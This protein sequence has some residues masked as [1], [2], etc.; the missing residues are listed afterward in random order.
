MPQPL[1]RSESR[2]RFVYLLQLRYA[3]RVFRWTS[4]EAVDIA[5]DSGTLH[6]RAGLPVSW[7]D[8]GD[9]LSID[10]EQ[11][12]VSFDALNMPEDVD[13]A[14][15]VEAGHDLAAA[16]GELS[17][18]VTGRTYEERIP[19]LEGRAVAP[20]YGG[21]GEPI[22]LTIE[23]RL[24]DDASTL[25]N[26][27]G[28]VTPTTW[29]L[30][31][32]AMFG[33]AYP[34]VVGRPGRYVEADGTDGKTT[35]SPALLV[36]TSSKRFLVAGH[37]VQASTVR[38]I[39][40]TKGE[41]RDVPVSVTTDGLGR[42]VSP[43]DSSGTGL[44]IVAGDEYWVRWDSGSALVG[45][46]STTPVQ[47]AG[48]VLQYVLQRSTLRVDRGAMSGAVAYLNRYR[49]DF[50]VDDPDVSAWDW[51]ADNVLP[52]LPVSV[53]GGPRGLRP[54]L[55]RWDA[56][57]VD[58]VDSIQAGPDAVR[59]SAVSYSVE[60]PVQTVQV[61]YAPRGGEGDH[62]RDVT[63]A[64][65]TT[66]PDAGQHRAL[67]S[68]FVRYGERRILRLATDVVYDDA[69]AQLIASTLASTYALPRREV[70]YELDPRR[71][72]TLEAGQVVT[73]TD[74]EIHL[75]DAV[76]V[77]QSIEWGA[78][79]MSVALVLTEDPARDR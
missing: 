55:F 13:V 17:I 47:Q 33:R 28:H 36:N 62:L 25:L 19:L 35:G 67:R 69:T 2:S 39:N 63:L 59:V 18:W 31:D 75:A 45:D 7:T 40:T 58:A 78:V 72:G 57:A 48:D 74:S 30:A 12:S 73:L 53:V 65:D 24:Y 77:V 8:G 26:P 64:G 4:G 10:S 5:S 66:T 49:L 1:T 51:L 56:R 46:D 34:L 79:T 3:S 14:E 60:E 15:L 41:A 29:P 16:L 22:A 6:Y 11:R 27:A 43:G 21:Q 32:P 76:A 54:V 50:Y 23:E 37:R 20:T 38:I 70:V 61:S 71:F 9:V 42:E 52:L 44:S 68:S